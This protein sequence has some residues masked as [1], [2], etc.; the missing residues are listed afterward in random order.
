MAKSLIRL[1]SRRRLMI[2]AGIFLLAA[3]FYYAWSPGT[4]ITDGRHDL[5]H[6]AIWMAHGYLGDDAWFTR[7]NKSDLLPACRDSIRLK[8][9]AELFRRHHITDLF[10]HLC[11]A[12]IDGSLPALDHDQAE[13]LLDVFPESE[14]RILPWVGGVSTDT[15]HIDD[16]AWRKQF[17]GS[18]RGLLSRH[19]R[20]A[21]IHVNI[22]PCASGNSNFLALLDELHGVL[23]A[24]KLLSIAAYPP[25][26]ILHHFPDLHWEESYFRQVAGRCNQMVVMLY[27]TGLHNRRLYQNLLCEWTREVIRWSAPTPILLGVP[28]YDDSGVGYHDPAIENIAIS[29]PGLHSGLLSF[30][31]LPAN[32]QGVA[33]YS[34]WTM[35]DEKWSSF[36]YNFVSRP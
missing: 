22:E 33:L 29:L 28:A 3:G 26:T 12:N 1:P 31:A 25:P 23:P 13:R 18:C 7:N 27:D 36:R 24:G 6:N 5:H 16:V 9:T 17:A 14:F 32:Y 35:T 2:Y 4:I 8:Q 10:V 11:P 20:F 30:S 34:Q 19:P 15:A 21:G